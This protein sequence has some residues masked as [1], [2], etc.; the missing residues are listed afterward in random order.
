MCVCQRWAL[1]GDKKK[2][3]DSVRTITEKEADAD[4]RIG[5]G[6]SDGD[7]DG[8][9]LRKIGT[10]RGREQRVNRTNVRDTVRDRISNNVCPSP[11][12]SECSVLLLTHHPPS[13]YH[14]VLALARALH[15][16]ATAAVTLAHPSSSLVVTRRRS[17]SLVASLVSTIAR[18][19]LCGPASERARTEK[20]DEQVC[21]SSLSRVFL[22]KSIRPPPPTPTPTASHRIHIQE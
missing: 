1:A 17:S 16:A 10:Q 20:R 15:A 2:G 11:E 3:V 7:G 9:R 22:L 8:D 14:S 19:R 13:T 4:T 21:P 18:P 5:Q 6:D 12:C